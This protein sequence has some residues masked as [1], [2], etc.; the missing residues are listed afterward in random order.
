MSVFA[1][2]WMTPDFD[3]QL[4]VV[5]TR[6]Q[7][8]M[9]ALHA[10][11]MR[12]QQ[13]EDILE[14]LCPDT[15]H[16]LT[17]KRADDVVDTCN[18]FLES[19]AYLD[20]TGKGPSTLI[21][22]GQRRSPIISNSLTFMKLGPEN[23]TSCPLA[24]SN[25]ADVSSV[26]FHRLRGN[27]Q[28]GLSYFVFN[29][30]DRQ[31]SAENV[32]RFLL[33]QIVAQLRSLPADVSAEYSKFK[34]D[35]HHIMPNKDKFQSLFKSSLQQLCTS[36]S[37]PSC[38][39]LDAYDEFRNDNGEER[40]RAE[41]QSF[42]SEIS[43]AG[44]AKILITTRPHCSK[45]LE[46]AFDEPQI[47]EFRGELRDVEQYLDLQLQFST[48][49]PAIKDLIRKAML[50]RNKDEPW[51]L[52]VQSVSCSLNRFLLVILQLQSVLASK[53]PVKLKA[54]LKNLPNTPTEA[55]HDLLNRMTPEDQDLARRILGWVQFAQRILTMGE[56][57]EALALDLEGPSLDINDCLEPHQVVSI[58]GGLVIHNQV[59]DLVTFSHETVR[60]FLETTSLPSHL[61]LS[62]TCLAYLRLPPLEKP[63]EG[64]DLDQRKKEFQ[65]SVYA[66]TFWAKHSVQ[67]GRDLQLE[68]AIL[69]TFSSDGRRDAMAQLRDRYNARRKSLL[70][71][72]IENSLS[73]IF[74]S[75]IS[76]E[77]Q[78]Q[79]MHVHRSQ[80]S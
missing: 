31:Q 20:W 38:I 53:D 2:V 4:K 35:P 64:F 19:T 56:L 17:P 1:K 70:H 50:E 44:T 67:A 28:L 37:S 51:Y 72:L 69:E 80:Y 65:F 58:C 3:A 62:K 8:Y 15:A 26:I 36:R 30:S 13:Q 49:K 29:H 21:C 41:L 78:F 45:E 24:P 5:D 12:E 75:P 60:P 55:Y 46:C 73:F 25:F 66:A 32:I 27:P 14:W 57:Q 68:I 61:V 6:S 9:S 18:K 54:R 22:T 63:S 76:R 10:Q 34:M 47:V 71:V 43:H 16:Y 11:V 52:S 39:L 33:R 48:L 42:L 59:N 23:H 77:E 7:S 74:W 40:E 79:I